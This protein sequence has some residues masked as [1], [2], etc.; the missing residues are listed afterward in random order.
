MPGI[1]VQK[2]ISLFSKTRMCN[3][4]SVL[5]QQIKWHTKKKTLHEHLKPSG[6]K[7]KIHNPLNTEQQQSESQMIWLNVY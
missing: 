6:I 2:K 7:K 1:F 4:Y 3:G 5:E